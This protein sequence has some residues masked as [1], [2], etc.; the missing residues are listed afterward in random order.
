VAAIMGI[1]AGV[2]AVSLRGLRSP[3]LAS[4]AN[5]VASA[6]KSARQ[7]AIASGRKTYLAVPIAANA[8]TTNLFRSYAIFE[9]VPRGEPSR[10]PPYATNM[11]P[12]VN[13]GNSEVVCE[14]LTDWRTLPDG[15]VFCN[16]AAGSYSPNSQPRE[17]EMPPT[18]E[19]GQ[20]LGRTAGQAYGKEEWKYFES[21]TNLA[22]RTPGTLAQL[23]DPI[24]NASFLGF[25]PSGRGCYNGPAY[26]Q[27]AGFR[28]AVGFVRGELVAITDIR[29]YYVVET[30]AFTGRV[31]VR[32]RESFQQ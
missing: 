12:L 23:N 32:A 27:G 2:A 30:D 3:A 18:S 11:P 25:Y 17:D 20:L 26:G 14:A 28:L 13:A 19:L 9:E 5:E 7:M 8:Y 22:V 15:V 1:L 31:R 24:R 4:A 10:N 29:N 21:F 16:L 6:M